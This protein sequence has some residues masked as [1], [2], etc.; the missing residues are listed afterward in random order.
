M[1]QYFVYILASKRLVL[2]IGVT[3]DLR[4][5]IYEHKNGIFEGFTKQY[6]VDRLLYVEPF[7]DITQAIAR[8]KQLKGWSRAKKL[9][10]IQRVNPEMNEITFD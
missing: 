1:Q 9:V 4:R 7:D 2:Y 10:L 8:E 5:R 6:N 3:N